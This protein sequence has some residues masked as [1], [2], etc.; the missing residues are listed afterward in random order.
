MI[1]ETGDPD[2]FPELKIPRSTVR[3]WLHRGIPRVVTSDSLSAERTELLAEMQELRQRTAVLGAIV[4]LLVAIFHVSERQLDYERLPEGNGKRALL[5][6]IEGA[7]RVAPRR[8]PVAYARETLISAR[9]SCSGLSA[10]CPE[11]QQARIPTSRS[12]IWSWAAAAGLRARRGD[13]AGAAAARR[14]AAAAPARETTR[15]EDRSSSRPCTSAGRTGSIRRRDHREDQ[16][17]APPARR[18]SSLRMRACSSWSR[19]KRRNRKAPVRKA[20]S[21]KPA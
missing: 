20:V 5:R 15:V 12:G 2:L 13:R 1:C 7:S 9:C 16:P 10:E 17:A 18:S 6:A 14:P 21:G 4:G 11:M 3:S 8:R 19:R